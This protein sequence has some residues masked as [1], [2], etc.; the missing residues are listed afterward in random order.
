MSLNLPRTYGLG[1]SITRSPVDPI[2]IISMTFI[3]DPASGK[4]L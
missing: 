3:I 4:V 2:R 1:F